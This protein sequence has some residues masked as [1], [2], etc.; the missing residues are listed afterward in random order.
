LVRYCRARD[1]RH[2]FVF[3]STV[4]GPNVFANGHA[5]RPHDD[6]G[7]H[8]R[9]SSGG[10]FDNIASQGNINVRNRGNWGTGH[11]WAGAYMGIWHSAAWGFIGRSSPTAQTWII[12]S[13]GGLSSP[14]GPGVGR[15]LPPISDSHTC[16]VEPP[17]LYAAQLAERLA[18]GGVQT[19]EY[20]L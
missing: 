8:H 2:D 9:W 5:E 19:R 14:R 20:R 1:G 3:G 17:S 11:G 6:I 10:L 7:P 16:P 15:L 18:F 13:V 4:A 12:G